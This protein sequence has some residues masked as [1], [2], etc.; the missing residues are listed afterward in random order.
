MS[1]SGLHSQEEV[2]EEDSRI[3]LRS[4]R[5]RPADPPELEA[6]RSGFDVPGLS[7]SHPDCWQVLVLE[8][9]A[10]RLALDLVL[11][12]WEG[13]SVLSTPSSFHCFSRLSQGLTFLPYRR[14]I[15]LAPG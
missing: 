9:T 2:V 3:E 5:A 13:W 4:L 1:C 14:D 8:I 11:R 15:C 10:G 7:A 12:G 6:T